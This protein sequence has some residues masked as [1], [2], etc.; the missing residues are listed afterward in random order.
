MCFCLAI[1]LFPLCGLVASSLTTVV[2]A[3]DV[4]GCV[5]LVSVLPLHARELFPGNTSMLLTGHDPFV[6]L[7]SL[8]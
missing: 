7:S 5:I 2:L 4:S 3:G 1:Q 8:D 6:G